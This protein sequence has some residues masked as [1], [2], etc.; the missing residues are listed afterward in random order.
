MYIHNV[1][2]RKVEQNFINIIFELV[3]ALKWKILRMLTKGVEK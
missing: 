1:Q 2:S 3:V